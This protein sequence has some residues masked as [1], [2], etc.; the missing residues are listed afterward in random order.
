MN[1][2]KWHPN[3]LIAQ[4]LWRHIEKNPGCA[5][6]DLLEWTGYP[7]QNVGKSL[8]RMLRRGVIHVSGYKPYRS[9]C[10]GMARRYCVGPGVNAEKPAVA[11]PV[12][13][14]DPQVRKRLHAITQATQQ[15]G[16]LAAM[17]AQL[18]LT[19]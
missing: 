3:S 9:A 8:R 5:V 10:D 2:P 17:V 12:R 14:E 19:T 16:A 6:S 18:R 4:T 7:R 11:Q 1:E 13:T 15:G